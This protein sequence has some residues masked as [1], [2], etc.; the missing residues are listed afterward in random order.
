MTTTEEANREFAKNSPHMTNVGSNDVFRHAQAWIDPEVVDPKEV[1]EDKTGTAEKP[2]PMR[3][4]YLEFPLAMTAIA[5]V[6]AY[7]RTKHAPRGWQ[8]FDTEYGMNYHR[9]KVGRHMLKEELEGP[10]NHKDGDLL[11]PAQTAWN[12]LAY[13]EHFLRF[14]TRQEMEK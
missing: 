12:I 8:T 7:G 10:V 14:R 2:D 13:L 5:E 3:D 4:V 6:T 1:Y 11:H 9:S